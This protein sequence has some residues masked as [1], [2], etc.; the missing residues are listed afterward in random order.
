MV[1]LVAIVGLALGVAFGLVRP[2]VYTADARL[3]VGQGVNITDPSAVAGLA[4][5]EASLASDYSRLISTQSVIA[6]AGA[7]L[8]HPDSLGG[9]LDASPIPESDIIRVDGSA[10]SAAAAQALTNAGAKALVDEVNDIINAN[11]QALNTDLAQYRSFESQI[12]NDTAQEQADQ[13]RLASPKADTASLQD[14]I[15]TL[16]SDIDALQLEATAVD[17][18]YTAQYSPVQ[19]EEEVL[20]VSS[21]AAP[22]GNDK[23]EFL[24]I[25]V[26]AGLLGGALVGVAVAAVMEM[27]PTLRRRIEPS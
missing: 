15:T 20:R 21:P 26:M 12:S 2:P 16:K 11:N 22:T 10:G 8:G 18:D 7:Q 25:G 27:L 19:E 3:I 1:A 4:P 6:D 17:D 24:E 23:S 14:Q 5:A 13:N 9:T